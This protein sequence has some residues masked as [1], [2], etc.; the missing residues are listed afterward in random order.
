MVAFSVNFEGE[1]TRNRVSRF[2]Q[3]MP[4]KVSILL[5]GSKLWPAPMIYAVCLVRIQSSVS[6]FVAERSNFRDEVTIR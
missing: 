6:G 5:A 4:K 1:R 2:D 3:T